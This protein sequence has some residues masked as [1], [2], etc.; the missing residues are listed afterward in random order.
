VPGEEEVVPIIDAAPQLMAYVRAAAILLGALFLARVLR[1]RIAASRRLAPQHRML[2]RPLVG[3]ALAAVSVL[4][5][6]TELGFHIGPMLGAAGILT[7]AIGFA[8]QTSVSNLISGV[9]LMAER[10]FVVGDVITI[11]PTTGEV[12]SVNLMSVKLRTFDNLMVRLP[13][14]TVLKSE[15]TNV[16]YFPIRRL[17]IVLSVAYRESI[18]RVR[19]LLGEVAEAN[20]LCLEEPKSLFIFLGFGESGLSMQFSVWGAGE[21]FIEMRN[22]MYEGIK[23]RFDEAG[24]ELPFPHRTLYAGSQSAPLP[25]RLVRDDGEA[26]SPHEDQAE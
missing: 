23:E 13:N 7:V 22:S 17:D 9:F 16:S 3:F 4:W 2:L 5:A 8:A 24:V 19:E 20:P 26:A 1:R 18:P 25:I 12:L 6:F 14:E 11:G 15:V 10:P 21:T